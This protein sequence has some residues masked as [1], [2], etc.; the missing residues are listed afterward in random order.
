MEEPEPLVSPL[1]WSDVRCAASSRTCLEQASD[2]LNPS[3]RVSRGPLVAEPA[4]AEA[5]DA[6][7][8]SPP[9]NEGAA[10]ADAPMP[11]APGRPDKLG[12]RLAASS[13]DPGGQS[14]GYLAA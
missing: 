1:S 12:G 8:Y 13:S 7:D 9:D 2:F 14:H 4:I 10:G 6:P 11:Q 3:G 5:E